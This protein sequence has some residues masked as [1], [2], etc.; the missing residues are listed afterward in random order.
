MSKLSL[1]ITRT[2]MTDDHFKIPN[3]FSFENY[4]H[5]S[6][7]VMQDELY[8]VVIRVNEIFNTYTCCPNTDKKS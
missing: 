7:K 1:Y 6:F 4:I 2:L 5:H 3:T 8:G